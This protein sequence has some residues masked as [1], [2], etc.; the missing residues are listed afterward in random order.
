MSE[1]KPAVEETEETEAPAQ[2]TV[3]P[4][5][6]GTQWLAGVF[7]RMNFDIDIEA[8]LEDDHLYFD[9]SGEDAEYLLGIGTS[10]PKSIES[11]QTLL[12]AALSRCGEKR[13]VTLDVRGWRDQRTDRLDNV[14]A[15]LRDVAVKLGK[16]VTVAGL[17]SYERAI[18][19]KALE[20]DK[21]V[22]T[23]SEGQG[24][25]RKLSIRPS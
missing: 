2:E 14:A 8:R 18:V 3:D 16:Q 22:K 12:S 4:L 11:I 21:S 19:H 20:D 23:E 5:A 1:E 6:Y 7:E 13:P 15:E 9:A 10:A 24:I 25:F 17:N